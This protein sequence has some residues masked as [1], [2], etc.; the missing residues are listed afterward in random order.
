VRCVL[1]AILLAAVLM[2]AAVPAAASARAP[3]AAR[4]VGGTTVTGA[5]PAP[6]P[7]MAALVFKAAPNDR[8][9]QFCGGSLIAHDRVLTAAH[10]AL[11]FDPA[12][13]SWWSAASA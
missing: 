8:A 6:Y 4:V 13:S 2:T 3:D 5:D 12:D 9:G 10:C 7:F 11:G 1:R